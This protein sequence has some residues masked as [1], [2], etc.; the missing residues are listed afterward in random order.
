MEIFKCGNWT[1]TKNGIQ[2]GGQQDFL[3]PL[4]HIGQSGSGNRIKMYETLVDLTAKTWLTKEDISDL[5]TAYIFALE[6]FNIG[7][8]KEISLVETF[9]EQKKLLEEREDDPSSDELTLGG[10]D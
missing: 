1:L 10:G 8:S 6:Y 9:Q 5:N 3:I 4:T 2:W 7:F